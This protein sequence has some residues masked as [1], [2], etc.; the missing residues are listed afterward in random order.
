[1]MT[2]ADS[3]SDEAMLGAQLRALRHARGLSLQEVSDVSGL[4]IGAISQ[5]E[6]GLTNPSIKSLRNLA[7]ALGVS[8]GWLFHHGNSP[9]ERDRGIIVRQPQR[10]RMEFEG[11]QVKELLTP[12]LT[13]ALEML[14]VSLP[15]GG[16]SGDGP[17]T[18][19]GE[20]AGLVLEGTLDLWVDAQHYRLSEGDSFGFASTRP[21]QFANAGDGVMRVLWVITPPAF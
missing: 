3:P 6:R 21:H 13:G 11:G 18:H 16:T 20:E 2:A 8:V 5:I 19:A 15:K 14:L 10:R 1:M 9:N 12:N 17:Y 7:D 4:S